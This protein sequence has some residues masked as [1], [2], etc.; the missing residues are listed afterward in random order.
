MFD[1]YLV[2]AKIKNSL[3]VRIEIKQ[4]IYFL[5]SSSFCS[6]AG[7]IFISKDEDKTSNSSLYNFNI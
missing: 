4:S 7:E 6:N 5:P 2:H 1:A 3:D